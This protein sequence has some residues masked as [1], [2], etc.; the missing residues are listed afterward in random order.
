MKIKEFFGKTGI[1]G[2]ILGMIIIVAGFL[3]LLNVFFVTYTMHGQTV[4]VPNIEGLSIKEAKNK[5]NNAG[6]EFMIADSTYKNDLPPGQVLDQSPKKG[7]TVKKFRKIYLTVSSVSAEPVKMP[8]LIDNSR[9]QAIIILESYGLKLGKEN[10]VPIKVGVGGIYLPDQISWIEYLN[11][12]PVD[13]YLVPVPYY[14]KPGK[15]GQTGWF[16]SLLNISDRP[17]CIYNVPGRTAVK[18]DV[19][20]LRDISS[21]DNFWA[22]KE[23]SGSV[24][25]FK[26]YSEASPNAHMLS[27]DDPMFAQF[28][29]LGAKGVVSVAANVW[30]EQTQLIARQFMSG[31]FENEEIF[32]IASKSLFSASNPIPTKSIL[33]HLGNI[34]TPTV[35]PPLSAKDMMGLDQIVAIDKELTNITNV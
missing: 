4:T 2:A 30:P 33:N 24:N 9:R 21:H 29:R 5:L 19:E 13:A 28:S 27:G 7:A 6:L 26:A 35:R 20:A 15:I 12:I 8:N 10:Y 34:E 31:N 18:L 11:T 1:L 14:T 17:V 3:F 25:S 32:S 23:A 16:R 22:V